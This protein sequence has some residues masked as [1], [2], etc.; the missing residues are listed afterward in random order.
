[1]PRVCKGLYFGPKH[2]FSS[3]HPV[4]PPTIQQ[5]VDIFSV[6]T[7]SRNVF[8]VLLMNIF[9]PFTFYFSLCFLLFPFLF[10]SIL[11]SSF[12]IQFIH[13]SYT[14]FKLFPQTALNFGIC[15]IKRGLKMYILTSKCSL[16]LIS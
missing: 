7:L 14:F 15:Y 9:Y 6:F 13:F 12:F 3:P 16:V 2:T 10:L 4:P 1:V 5:Y 11:I 8:I